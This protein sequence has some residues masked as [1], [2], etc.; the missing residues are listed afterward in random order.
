MRKLLAALCFAALL[1]VPTFAADQFTTQVKAAVDYTLTVT[2]T[3]GT[4]TAVDVTQTSTTLGKLALVSNLNGFTLTVHSAT[5]SDM[6]RQGG[7][8]PYPYTITITSNVLGTL[9]T[10]RDLATDYTYTSAGSQP[11][12]EITFVVNYQKAADIN[13]ALPAGIYVDTLTF[14]IAS[15]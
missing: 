12:S 6:I 11:A 15:N 9:V 2:S 4:Q 14:T 13:P 3:I 10:A 5:G 1:A 8:D 7:T